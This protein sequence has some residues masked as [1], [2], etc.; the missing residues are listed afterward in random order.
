MKHST[1][2]VLEAYK[3][4]KLLQ[5]RCSLT[6]L[7]SLGL[8]LGSSLLFTNHLQRL[9]AEHAVHSSSQNLTS[10]SENNRCRVDR[11][12]EALPR[13]IISRTSDFELRPL[14]GTRNDQKRSKLSMNLLAMTAGI[15]QKDNVNKIVMKFMLNNFTVM[16]FHYDGVVDEWNKFE[17]SSRAIHVSAVSQTKWWFAKRFLHPD[18]VSEYEYIFLWDEDLEVDNFDPGRYI[19][20]VKEEVLEISQPALDPKSYLHHPITIRNSTVKLHR[21]IVQHMDAGFECREDS[22]GPPCTGWVEMMAPVFSRASWHCVW[23][24]IQNDLVHGWGMDYLLGYCAQ[25][26]RTKNVGVVDSEYVFHPGK[27]LLGGVGASKVRYVQRILSHWSKVSDFRRPVSLGKLFLLIW[28]GHNQ[29]NCRE[30]PKHQIKLQVQPLQIS[31]GWT[32]E[33]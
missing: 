12:T 7:L 4:N 16:I 19:S 26:D 13:G 18:I 20:I 5:Y 25:G 28:D 30:L 2:N 11:G 3:R 14:L 1:Y 22:E 27:V 8:F 23:H 29:W 31:N 21:R 33:V 32:Q 17:W 15:E 24:L 6:L 10:K 9:Q